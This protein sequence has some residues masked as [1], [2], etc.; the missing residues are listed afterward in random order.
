VV[1]VDDDSFE[2]APETLAP[3]LRAF[4]R[5]VYKLAPQLLLLLDT[6][7]VLRFDARQRGQS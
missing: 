7:A 4:I 5:G 6:D 1:D 3:G 2:P